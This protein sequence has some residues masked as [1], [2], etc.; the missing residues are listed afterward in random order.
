[1]LDADTLARLS[2]AAAQ[3]F[4]ARR[5][6]AAYAFGSRVSGRPRPDS[7]LDVGYYLQGYRRSEALP[8][9][10][11]MRLATELSRAAGVEID[12]R[13][14]GEA[15]LEFRG[16]VLEDGIRVFEADPA[17]RVALERDLLARYHDYK[18]EFEQMHE[19]RLRAVAERGL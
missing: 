4:P 17:A 13:N 1:M 8:I 19:R 10:E 9:D 7:D 2:G 6:L 3:L 5:I 16:R 15:S 12:L 14:L 18:S 11:E